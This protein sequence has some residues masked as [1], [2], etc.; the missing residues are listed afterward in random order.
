MTPIPKGCFHFVCQIT[1]GEGILILH[2][3]PPCPLPHTH[4]TPSSPLY[5][6]IP[7]P[8][9]HPV[10]VWLH[11]M[12][13]CPSPSKCPSS[14]R[15][16]SRPNQ[17]IRVSVTIGIMLNFDGHGDVRCSQA[18]TATPP[19]PLRPIPTQ[20]P[21]PHTPLY[22]PIP[23]PIPTTSHPPSPPPCWAGKKN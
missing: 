6:P 1:G 19:C 5:L 12:S 20:F 9:P 17:P 15:M 2:S 4:P 3:S 7:I 13:P 11:L 14:A 22:H 21:L 16:G 23:S 8:R 10:K 18:L